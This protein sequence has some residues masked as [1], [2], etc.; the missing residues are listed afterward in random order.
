MASELAE[1]PKCFH[2][3]IRRKRKGR[4]PI[5]PLKDRSNVISDD[6]AM[7]TVLV[8]YFGS[9]FQQGRSSDTAV[10]QTCGEIMEGLRS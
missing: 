7:S 5:G 4:A 2:A 8:K 6:G 10:H 1:R 3:Y 9:V